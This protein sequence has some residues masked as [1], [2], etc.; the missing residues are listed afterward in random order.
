MAPAS[1]PRHSPILLLIVSA[2]GVAI[3]CGLGSWQL[4]RRVEKEA[5]LARLAAQALATPAALP[6]DLASAPEAL[7]L[8]RVSVSGTWLPQAT[9]TVRVVMGDASGTGRGP[10]G[11]GRYLIT[12]MKLPD[13]RVLLVNRGFAPEQAVAALPAPTGA[14]TVT[15]FLR[16]PEAPNAFTPAA[17]PARR[18]FHVRDPASIAAALSLTAEPM[19]LDQERGPDARALPVGLDARELIARIPNNHLQYALTWFGLALT[20]IGVAGAF[21]WSQRRQG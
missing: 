6:A 15:G 18:D 17:D 13:G 14:A 2:I 12:A 5:F 16:R 4:Q 8:R 21:L 19:M 10:Q 1:T 20:L 9:A 3:L 7:D 11:F